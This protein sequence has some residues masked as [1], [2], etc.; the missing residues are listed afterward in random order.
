[1]TAMSLR[2]IK[3]HKVSVDRYCPCQL[4]LLDIDRKF[5]F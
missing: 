5:E 3:S 1:M 2:H 4:S